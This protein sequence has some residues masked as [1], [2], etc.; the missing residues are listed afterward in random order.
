MSR[1]LLLVLALAV[2]VWSPVQAHGVDGDHVDVVVVRGNLDERLVRFV[3]DAVESSSASLVILQVDVG[4]VLDGGVDRLVALIADPPVPLALWVGPSPAVVRGAMAVALS[5]APIRGAAPGAVIEEAS[6]MVVGGDDDIDRIMELSPE[7]PDGAIGGTLVIGAGPV[8]GLVDLVEPSI[9]QFIVGLHG[10]EV[11][12]AGE[13]VSLDTARTEIV[14]G[15][16]S[17]TPAHSV[18]FVE[19]GVI[20]RVLATGTQAATTFFFLVMGLALV[21]FEFYAV[22]PGI[23]AAAAAVLLLLAGNGLVV[24]PVWWPALVAVLVGVVLYVIEFQRNDLGWKSILGTGLL[25]FGGLTFVGPI[26]HLRPSWWVIV[27]VVAAAALFFGFALTTVAR[28]RFA[29]QTIGRD[30]LIDRVGSAEGAI[31]P[32]GFVLVDG[33]RWKARSTRAAGIESGDPVRVVAV[34]GIVLEVEPTE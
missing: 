19:P 15:V 5:V 22:G 18:R 32:E 17:I 30:H 29:T 14:D 16:E 8:P 27:L 13:V 11:V 2:S 31:G 25:L 3:I 1:R 23:A 20:D 6:P 34:T 7:F 28:S 10:T 26:A 24:L 33:A 9:G 12:V 21:A 4:V